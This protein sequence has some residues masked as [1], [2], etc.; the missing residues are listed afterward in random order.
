M[1]TY[2]PEKIKRLKEEYKSVLKEDTVTRASPAVNYSSSEEAEEDFDADEF[3][4][5]GR[6]FVKGL[7]ELIEQD[8]RPMRKVN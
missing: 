2:T 4:K 1:T 6:E 3:L 5:N 8:F 7:G